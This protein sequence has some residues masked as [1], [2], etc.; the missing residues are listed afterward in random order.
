MQEKINI[1][2]EEPGIRLDKFLAQNFEQ[3]S[4]SQ[5]QELILAEQVFENDKIISNPASKTKLAEYKINIGFIKQKPSH[6]EV[7]DFPLD[8][9]FEDEYLL[10]INKPAGLTVHPGA[11]N[12]DKTLANALV[13]Y[14]KGQ[15]STIG[16]E[17]RPGIVH[18]LDKDTSGLIIIAKDDN[19]HQL[20]SEALSE[21]EIKR[22]YLAIVMGTPELKAGTIKTHIAKHNHDHTKMVITKN[23]G[24]EAITHYVLVENTSDNKFSILECKLD[25]GRTHQIR[26]H[27]NYKGFPVVGDP[28]YND[29]QNKYICR[30]DQQKKEL[31][32]NFTRQ[33]LHAYRLEFIH[34]ITEEELEF[35]IELPE[36][37][38]GLWQELQK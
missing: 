8:I 10:V 16:G 9:V 18:R 2:C 15:L 32:K 21:R 38:N 6:L 24:K 23:T 34:P 35:E 25:T 22:Y 20:L 29:A 28:L 36:D 11:G 3:Y 7:Y 33:A 30:L 13:F 4:R 37:M 12:H 14:A 17:F 5:M 19:T 1:F 26:I 31:V 27:L